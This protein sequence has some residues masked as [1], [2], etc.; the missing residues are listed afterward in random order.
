M[1]CRV[2]IWRLEDAR[3]GLSITPLEVGSTPAT[4]Y[5]PANMDKAPAVTIAHGFAGSRQL[6]E[7]Y[8]LTLAAPSCSSVSRPRPTS[9]GE[10]T[11][12]F[13]RIE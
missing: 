12:S 8:A 5:R 13:S 1:L 4:A 7:A 3:P 11:D 9:S 2:G 10:R 6:M